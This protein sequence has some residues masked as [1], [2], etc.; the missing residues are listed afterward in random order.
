MTSTPSSPG[1]LEDMVG[2]VTR[3]GVGAVG[4]KLI[5]PDRTLNHCGV[6]VGPHGGLADTPFVKRHEADVP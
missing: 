1:W 6:I 3:P 5:Y 2:W 4:A